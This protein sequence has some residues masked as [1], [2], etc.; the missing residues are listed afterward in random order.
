MAMHETVEVGKSMC[1]Q[2]VSPGTRVAKDGRDNR[3]NKLPEVVCCTLLTALSP[4]NWF[5]ILWTVVE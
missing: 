5:P 1:T 2:H 4:Y 3:D